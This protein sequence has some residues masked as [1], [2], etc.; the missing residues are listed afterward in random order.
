MEVGSIPTH[1]LAMHKLTYDQERRVYQKSNNDE[2]VQWAEINRLDCGLY[3]K[4]LSRDYRMTGMSHSQ[5]R[6]KE[7]G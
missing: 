5:E 3:G 6:K 7:K 1:H 4:P 2:Q